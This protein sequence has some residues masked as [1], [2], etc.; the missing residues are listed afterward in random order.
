MTQTTSSS[1]IDIA[2]EYLAVWTQPDPAVRRAG[3]ASVWAPDGTEF[4]EGVQFRGYDELDARVTRAYEAFFG[5]G[6]Y[7]LTA[8]DDITV[9]DDMAR[10][11]I[12][13][14]EPGGENAWTARVILLVSPDGKVLEDY[15]VVIKPLPPA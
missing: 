8:E 5:S 1:I 14:T 6:K 15:H 7:T 4:L 12:H 11:T 13:L 2:R 3:V 10:F 9:H